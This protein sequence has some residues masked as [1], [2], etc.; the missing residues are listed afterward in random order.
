M[1]NSKRAYVKKFLKAKTRMFQRIKRLLLHGLGSLVSSRSPL[2]F[3]VAVIGAFSATVAIASFDISAMSLK[4]SKIS[5]FVNK[6]KVT[7]IYI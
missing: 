2:T 5:T 4:L 1:H 3:L 6:E 7:V